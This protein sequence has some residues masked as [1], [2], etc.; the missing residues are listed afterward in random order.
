MEVLQKSDTFFNYIDRLTAANPALSL[1]IMNRNGELVYPVNGRGEE[2]IH[3]IT[4]LAHKQDIPCLL[5]TS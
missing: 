5:D 2:L 1:L 3:E 4:A